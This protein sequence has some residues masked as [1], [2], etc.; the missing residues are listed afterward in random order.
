MASIHRLRPAPIAWPLLAWALFAWIALAAL[1]LPARSSEPE[2]RAL[3]RLLDSASRPLASLPA[4]ARGTAIVE[5]ESPQLTATLIVS[6]EAPARV[7]VL[8]EMAPGWHLY[9]RNPGE[10][11]VAPELEL[12]ADGY[13]VGAVDWPVPR[14]FREA[15]D[16]FT[17]YGYEGHVLLAAD[18][19]ADPDAVRGAAASAGAAT[20]SATAA[21]AVRARVDVLACRTQCVP[22]SFALAS[23]LALDVDEAV[24]AEIRSLFREAEARL[25]VPASAL[26]WEFDA[27]WQGGAPDVDGDASLVLALEPCAAEAVG[28]VAADVRDPAPAFLPFE[29]ETFELAREQVVS[30]DSARGGQIELALEAT[31]LEPGEDRLSGVVALRD[32]NGRMRH[33]EIDVPI[34]THGAARTAAAPAG[35]IGTDTPTDAT[36]TSTPTVALG[37]FA[38]LQAILLALLGGLILNGMPC[39]LPVLAIKVVSV[40]DLAER[41]A[42]EV[43][44]HGLAYTAGVLGS[45]LALATL[46]VGL[47]GA[48]HAVGWGF[49]FQEPLFVAGIAALLVTFALNLFGVFEIELGQGRLATVGQDATGL[50][51][52]VF[53]GLLAVVLATPCTAPFLGTAVGFAFASSGLVIVSIFL[54]IGVGLASPFLL[55]SFF[56]ALARFVPRSGPWMLKLRAGLGFCLLATV[57]WL[58]WIVGQSGGTDAVV[59]LTA[60]LLF[61][62]FL[63]WTFGQLQPMRSVWLGRGSAVAI[64]LLAFASFNLIDFE[65]ADASPSATGAEAAES[66]LEGD[67][68]RPYDEAAVRERLAAGVPVFVVFTAD[69]CITC[70]VNERTVLDRPAVREALARDGFA[71]FRADWTRRDEG[72]R[73]KL[74][75][76]GRAGVPLYLVYDPAEPDRPRVLSELLSQEAVLAALEAAAPAARI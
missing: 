68:F 22:A 14:I 67:G 52:S 21:P 59:A 55:V 41:D 75:E 1:S 63:L 43:R 60:A 47:R 66:G 25:P 30:V 26:G 38:A 56:P 58:L 69:W 34:R 65:R 24:R 27:V 3:A 13:A 72:I 51:R 19:E 45:M 32:A 48:G 36:G 50:S 71:L 35:A 29:S 20:P 17:T 76:F 61:L 46:V 23:P 53:E 54:A 9:W 73:T 8:F 5:D 7:G 49:Q 44:L 62:A 70:K 10:T 37:S 6:P 11:G 18:L 64:T 40:A 31:R 16:L 2:S 33:V 15:D 28:C 42:N 12:D 39:V 57:I 74:A 4:S